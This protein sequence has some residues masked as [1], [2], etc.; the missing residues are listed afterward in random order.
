MLTCQLSRLFE[1]LHKGNLVSDEGEIEFFEETL[2]GCCNG[3]VHQ[4]SLTNRFT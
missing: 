2:Y 4:V 3:G 1:M